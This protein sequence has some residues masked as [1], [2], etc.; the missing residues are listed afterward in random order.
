MSRLQI[1]IPKGYIGVEKEKTDR[2]KVYWIGEGG[3]VVGSGGKYDF[4]FATK[5]YNIEKVY[6]LDFNRFGGKEGVEKEGAWKWGLL[7]EKLGVPIAVSFISRR[8]HLNFTLLFTWF[9]YTHLLFCSLSLS[10]SY[11]NPFG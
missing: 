7:C 11:L 4:R 5:I 3:R 6:K 8:R 1:C 2:H 9:P 10:L